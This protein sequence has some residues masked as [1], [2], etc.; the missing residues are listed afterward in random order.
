MGFV[1]AF[2][3]TTAVEMVVY[4]IVKGSLKLLTPTIE[5]KVKEEYGV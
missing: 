3:Q 2:Y 1:D 5:T 4:L